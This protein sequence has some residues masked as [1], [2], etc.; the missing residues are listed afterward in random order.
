MVDETPRMYWM[1]WYGTATV[2]HSRE[3]LRQHGHPWMARASRWA[4]I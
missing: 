3:A 4:G 2:R 1:H